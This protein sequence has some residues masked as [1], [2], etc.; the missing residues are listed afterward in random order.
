MN[1]FNFFKST[2]LNCID[3]LGSKF[4]SWLTV[5]GKTWDEENKV[6]VNN[7]GEVCTSKEAL[8]KFTNLVKGKE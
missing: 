3:D 2:D 6:W 8:A 4:G 5:T 1:L 7:K